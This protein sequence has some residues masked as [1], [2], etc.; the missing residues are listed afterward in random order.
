MTAGMTLA[1]IMSKVG[2]QAGQRFSTLF[3]DLLIVGGCA[4]K[5]C[6]PQGVC[7]RRRRKMAYHGEILDKCGLVDIDCSNVAVVAVS[8]DGPNVCGHLLLHTGPNRG[9][10]YFHVAEFHGRPRYMNESGYGRYLREAGKTELRRRYLSLPNPR[11]ALLC[12]H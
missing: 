3:A 4:L 9:G 1:V 12:G 8:G 2:F 5:G 11:G 6:G 10:L 7:A